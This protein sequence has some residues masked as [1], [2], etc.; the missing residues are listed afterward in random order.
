[1]IKQ[2][3]MDA[4]H[5]I[6]EKEMREAFPADE[7]KPFKRMVEMSEDGHYDVWGYFQ[8]NVLLAYAC[9]YRDM[10]IA[11]LDYFAVVKEHRAHGI[12]S[13]FLQELLAMKAAYKNMMIEIEAIEDAADEEMY[14]ERCRRMAFYERLGFKRSHVDA[15]V[16]GVHY[17]VMVPPYMLVEQNVQNYM[18]QVYRYFVPKP[19]KF[20]ENIYII[21]KSNA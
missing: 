11:L 12:G 15:Y 17:W 6:Y 10:D 1:M 3:D 21:E 9:I 5:V 4:L 14:K 2:L 13:T 8:E 16:F 20:K 7:L 18:T 19:E